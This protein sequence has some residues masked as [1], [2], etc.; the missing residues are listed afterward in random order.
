MKTALKLGL[1]LLGAGIFAALVW[2]AGPRSVLAQLQALGPG[3]LLF[4]LPSLG[5]YLLDAWA[6]VLC[7]R[8]RPQLSFARLFLIRQAGE[9]LNNTIP[10][11]YMGGEPV[12]ALLLTREGIPGSEGLASVVV[13]KTAMTVAQILFV[14]TGIAC[15]ALAKGAAESLPALLGASAFCLLFASGSMWIAYAAQRYGLGK[16]LQRFSQRV[17]VLEGYVERER[18]G[19]ERLDANLNAFYEQDGRRFWLATLLFYGG[20]S[21]E[22]AEVAVFAWLLGLPLSPEV[23]IAIGALATVVKAAGFFLP[24][25]L[26]AQEGGNVLL[27]LA[28]GLTQVAA[29]AFSLLRRVR[30]LLWIGLGL[31]VLAALG[32]PGAEPAAEEAAPSPEV[33]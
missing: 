1:F 17:G 21:C 8:E 12:K 3:A 25:S 33:P 29:V 16:L 24:G 20:W 27:F 11:A 23:V 6:W 5:I 4:L 15:A 18:E 30:E 31:V 22:V 10:S 9:A 2:Q 7:F 14:L 13:G 26:G 19:L 32:L 28:F